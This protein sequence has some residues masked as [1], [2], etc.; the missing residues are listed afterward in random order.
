M[1]LSIFEMGS[2]KGITKLKFDNIKMKLVSLSKNK[3]A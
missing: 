1:G 2:L 3:E